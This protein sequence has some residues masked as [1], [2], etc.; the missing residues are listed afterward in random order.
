MKRK[1]P[2]AGTTFTTLTT[3]TRTPLADAAFDLCAATHDSVAWEDAFG[4]VPEF[5]MVHRGSVEI[6][7][8]VELDGWRAEDG[9]RQTAYII[10]GDLDLAGLLVFSQSDICTT[11]WVTGNVTVGRLV[12]AGSAMLI[13]GGSLTVTETL[14]TGLGDAGHLIVDGLLTAPVWIDLGRGRGSIELGEPGGSPVESSAIRPELQDEDGPNWTRLL[15][16]IHG[17]SPVVEQQSRP[18]HRHAENHG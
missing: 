17:G 14:L 11:L 6:A 4:E 5:L 13:V 7:G 2:Q 3:W 1:R 8:P 15:D 9:A 16:A 10:D 12:L 18:D